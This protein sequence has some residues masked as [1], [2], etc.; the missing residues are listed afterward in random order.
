M[1]GRARV[2]KPGRVTGSFFVVA[3][4]HGEAALVIACSATANIIFVELT[5]LQSFTR[6]FVFILLF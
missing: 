4:S 6:I 1:E 3:T 5:A 2:G